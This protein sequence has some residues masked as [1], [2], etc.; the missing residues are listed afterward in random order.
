MSGYDRKTHSFSDTVAAYA[1]SI[2]QS[3]GLMEEYSG[4]L[5]KKLR[6]WI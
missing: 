6:E 5:P 3:N 1:I 4:A 2:S